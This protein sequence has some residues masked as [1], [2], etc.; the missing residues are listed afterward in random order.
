MRR[1][2]VWLLERRIAWHLRE[3]RHIQAVQD[4]IGPQLDRALRE[5]GQARCA[6]VWFTI[7]RPP[8]THARG[9][10][11]RVYRLIQPTTKE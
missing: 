1:L 7:D 3:V 5:L 10:P 11:P 8:I 4:A 2:R 9:E 6:L